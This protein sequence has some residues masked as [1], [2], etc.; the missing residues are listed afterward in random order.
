MAN[1]SQSTDPVTLLPCPFCGGEAAFNTIRYSAEHVREQNWGQDTFH[2][3]NCI[4]CGTSNRG[5]V[6]FRTPEAAAVK[7]NRRVYEF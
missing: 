2:G 5:I 4:I 1:D 3:V 6:G 7:W